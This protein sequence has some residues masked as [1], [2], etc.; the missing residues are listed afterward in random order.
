MY[1]VLILLRGFA[2][3]YTYLGASYYVCES[4]I[5]RLLFSQLS[6]QHLPINTLLYQRG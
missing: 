3:G 1:Y 6:L 2:S 5:I 4:L